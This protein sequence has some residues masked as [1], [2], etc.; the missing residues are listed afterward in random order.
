MVLAAVADPGRR[1][2]SPTQHTGEDI[3]AWIAA[4]SCLLALLPAVLFLRNLTLNA[5]PPPANGR[6]RACCSVLIPARNEESTIANAVR[7]VLQ[8]QGADFEVIV[9]DDDSADQT[10]Q[11]VQALAHEDG[12]VRLATAPPLPTGWCGKQHACH[13]L[14]Q[15]AQ[16]PLLVSMDADV[17]LKSDALSRIS[18]FMEQSGAAL[19]SGVPRQ[20]MRTFSERLLIPL[21]HFVLLGFLPINRMRASRDPVFGTGCGQLFI[22]RREAYHSSGGHS[23]IR[24]TLHDGLKLARVFRAAG[25]ATDLF[26]AT[27]IAECRMYSTN[28]EVWRGLAKNA[29]EGLGSPRLIGPATLLLLGGQIL[30]TCLLLVVCFQRPGLPLVITLLILGTAAAFLPRLM[31][32]VRFRQPLGGALLHPFGI[33]ALLAIQWFGFVRSLCHHP[34]VWKGR[35]YSKPAKSTDRG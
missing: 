19:A 29:H 34:A 16:H 10:G 27:C 6:A 25:F 13:V 11:I 12:R 32:V 24:A 15:L 21:I 26:D 14:A 18:A 9:L 28:A 31:A 8:T 1:F 35:T 7:S 2:R 33:F 5:P 22:A 3:I 17:R 30:P 4:T 23:V 20:E